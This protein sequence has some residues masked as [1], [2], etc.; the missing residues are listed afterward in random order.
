MLHTTE[1]RKGEHFLHEWE[2]R[3][4]EVSCKMK[5]EKD[6]SRSKSKRSTWQLEKKKFVSFEIKSPLSRFRCAIDTKSKV[7]V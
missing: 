5:K 2:K 6:I 7:I 1:I 4:K 3:P